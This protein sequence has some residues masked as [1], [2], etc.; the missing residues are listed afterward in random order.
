M[1]K[2]QISVTWTEQDY[3]SLQYDDVDKVVGRSDY[4]V[5][6]DNYNVAVSSVFKNL[7]QVFHN[8]VKFLN[9]KK[10]VV[11]V[12]RMIPEQILPFHTDKYKTYKKRNNIADIDEITRVIIFLHDQ[13]AGHQLWIKDKVC[14]GPAGSYF[15]WSK[16]VEH[17]AANFGNEDRYILQVTGIK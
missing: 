15:G 4:A 14:V 7:P 11:A 10:V 13:K 17:M 2:G 8:A 3:K 6:T 16:G 5:N 9:L 12:N 1:I